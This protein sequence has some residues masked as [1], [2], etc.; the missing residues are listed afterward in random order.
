MWNLEVTVTIASARDLDHLGSY[1]GELL[2]ELELIAG[3]AA[4]VVTGH[5]TEPISTLV[6]NI[7]I[8]TEDP[9]I[10]VS[11]ALQLIKQAAERANVPLG[12]ERTISLSVLD[13]LP[14]T[15]LHV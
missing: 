7:D 15:P 6:V 3:N 9:T 13:D 4:P 2:D 12:S 5:Y 11:E 10:A 1:A 14:N 8:A